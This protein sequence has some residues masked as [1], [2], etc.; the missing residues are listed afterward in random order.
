MNTGGPIVLGD[1]RF[2]RNVRR[3]KISIQA[4]KYLISAVQISIP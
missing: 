3:G 4:R 1:R 2:D